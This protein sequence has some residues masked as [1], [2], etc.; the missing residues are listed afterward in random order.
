[1]ELDKFNPTVAELNALVVKTRGIDASCELAIVKEN[2]IALKNAR[3][4]IEKA[5]KALRADA[6]DFQ[7]KVIA[8]ENEL[9]G[10]IEPEE[11]RLMVIEA[12]A[13]KKA[14][15]EA[16]K[17]LLPARIA[18]LEAIGATSGDESLLA[19]DG[20][21]FQQFYNEKVADKNER[22][23]LALEE[24]R[25]KDD[26]VRDAERLA[27]EEELRKQNEALNEKQ[28]L[29]DEEAARL[30]HE[31]QVQEAAETAR[32]EE[33]ERQER[34]RKEEAERAERMQCEENE[35]KEAAAKAEVERIAAEKAKQ[36]ADEKYQAF[37]KENGYY[38]EGEK[39][40]VMASAEGGQTFLYKLIATYTP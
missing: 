30:V 35:R 8:K 9:I 19:M 34:I 15:R 6:L 10:I 26:E 12:E 24:Q 21:Q 20:T 31:R 5:G 25:R 11:D 27:R 36:E 23:R 2:R 4:Q 40:M 7:K 18:Q 1:M 3:V 33:A 14:E 28:R 17:A 22:D 32:K 38:N 16:R 13:A 39:F 29:I 37:L